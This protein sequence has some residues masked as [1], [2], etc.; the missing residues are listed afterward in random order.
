M[1]NWRCNIQIWRKKFKL[2][3][4]WNFKIEFKSSTRTKM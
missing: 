2:K 1:N 4:I 3:K